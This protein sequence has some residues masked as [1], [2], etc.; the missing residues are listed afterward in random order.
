[1]ISR[2][3]AGLA[4]LT[5]LLG[6][7]IA[8][9]RDKSPDEQVKDLIAKYRALPEKDQ[10]GAEG[11]NIIKQL[12]GLPAAKLTPQSQEAVIR[13]QVERNLRQFTVAQWDPKA[14]WDPKSLSYFLI[15]Y[16]DQ[17][18]HGRRRWEYKV[19]SEGDV[20]KLGKEDLATGLNKLGEDGWELVGFEK[21]RF[22]FKRQKSV[23]FP[24]P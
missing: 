18:A 17:S 22:I 7:G 2:F 23:A 8:Q 3:M 1:M 9:Q 16:M 4:L 24:A 11:A 13:L 14:K 21:T 19:L 20:Q 5:I 6:T 12:I 15:P 10:K